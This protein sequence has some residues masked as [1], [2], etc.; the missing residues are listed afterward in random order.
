[1][2]SIN[3]L[4]LILVRLKLMFHL[5]ETSATLNHSWHQLEMKGEN[6]SFLDELKVLYIRLSSAQVTDLKASLGH[7]ESAKDTREITRLWKKDN[8]RNLF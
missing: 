7:L 3:F 8:V 6:L 2:L 4:S 1:M 5:M